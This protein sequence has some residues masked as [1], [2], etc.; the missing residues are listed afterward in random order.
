MGHAEPDSRSML[1]LVA[2]LPDQIAETRALLDAVELPEAAGIRRVAICGMGGSAAAGNLARGTLGMGRV[3]IEV[4]RSYRL[5]DS[6]DESCLLLFSTYSGTTEETLAAYED[7]RAR[8]P[9]CRRIAITTGGPLGERAAADGVAVVR[10]PDGY[11]PRAALGYGVGVIF[12]ILG[13]L[14]LADGM[15]DQL[16]ETVDVLRRGNDRYQASHPS[17]ENR[18]RSLARRLYGKLPLLYAAE[19]LTEAVAWRIKT[20]INEN[21]K[22][23][24]AVGVLPELDHN[25]VVGWEVATPVRPQVFVLALRDRQ[26]H[27]RVQRRFEITRDVLGDRVRDWETVESEGKGAVARAM[28]LVQF[29]DYLSVYLASEYGVDPKQVQLIDR[30]K[31][32]L[33]EIG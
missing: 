13:R 32:R 23:L 30:L 19:G 26:D 27:P 31:T 22:V 17:S 16:A 4:H 5:P 18:A 9:G 3:R 28:S 12:G 15:E 21:A 33:A 10:V 7:A 29:G 6:L 20:Q 24:A 14:G 1:D 2:M 11:P 8:F 25:E